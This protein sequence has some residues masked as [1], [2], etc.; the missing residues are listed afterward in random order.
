MWAPKLPTRRARIHRAPAEG[1]GTQFRKAE[2][3]GTQIR[4]A[5]GPGAQRRDARIRRAKTLSAEHPGSP[6]PLTVTAVRA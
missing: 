3:P 4:K 2:G 6:F 5:E 1:P